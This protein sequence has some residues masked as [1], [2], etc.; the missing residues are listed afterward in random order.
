MDPDGRVSG[1]SPLRVEQQRLRPPPHRLHPRFTR[2]GPPPPPALL[3]RI[4]GH[5]QLEEVQHG[6]QLQGSG[7]HSLDLQRSPRISAQIEKT[8]LRLSDR[9]QTGN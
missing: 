2:K 3:Q 6:R 4:I 1:A 7:G 5:R 9:R 8:Q